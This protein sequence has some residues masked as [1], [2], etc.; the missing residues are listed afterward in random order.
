MNV[1]SASDA[2]R[3]PRRPTASAN[4]GSNADARYCTKRGDNAHKI[5]EFEVLYRWHPW[6]GRVIH[7]HEVIDQRSGGVLQ[8]RPDGDASGRWLE[9][10]KWM[11]DRAAWPIRMAASP[12]VD[13]AALIALKACLADVL[14]AG[15]CGC[16][17]PNASASGAGRSS[18]NQ[19]QGAARATQVPPPT[20]PSSS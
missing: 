18:C 14:G 13:T 16:P 11:F 17:L 8:C 1:F 9:L 19:N 3:L 5:E 20:P 10:P 4:R 12:R 2:A 15:S 6:F 7:I